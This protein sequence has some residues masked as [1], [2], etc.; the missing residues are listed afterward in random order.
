MQQI[1]TTEQYAML[2]HN[3]EI[4]LPPQITVMSFDPMYFYLLLRPRNISNNS[5]AHDDQGDNPGQETEGSTVS[6]INSDR[7]SLI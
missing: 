2:S 7:S 3:V 1:F 5:Y 4:V 6:S